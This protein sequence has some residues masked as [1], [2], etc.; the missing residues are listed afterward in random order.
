MELLLEGLRGAAEPTRLRLLAVLAQSELTVSELTQISGLSQPRISRH[1]KLMC[2]AGLIDRFK[3]GAWVFYRLADQGEGGKLAQTLVSLLDAHDPELARDFV[4][5][6]DIRAAR[7]QEAEEYFRRNATQWDEIRS[8]YV[9][10]S[11]VERALRD[12]VNVG[13][14]KSNKHI[15]TFVDFGTGTGR[16]IEILGPYADVNLGLDVNREMLAIARTNLE[17]SELT[18]WQIRQGDI[19]AVPLADESADLVTVHQVLHY[20]SE[21][22]RV[23]SEAARILKPEGRLLIVDFAPHDLE[24]LRAEHAHRRL[25]FAKDEVASW[26]RS[27]GLKLVETR[28]LPPS[29]RGSG[30]KLTVVLWLAQKQGGK[31]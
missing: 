13:D 20:L 17:R 16:I 18:N 26:C 23:I 19:L 24:F 27:A 1:L 11:D 30:E 15:G 9:S 31:Q 22:E 2:A 7:A 5:L 14:S 29:Q 28:E 10:E 21:P 12:M 4:R 8:L 25:G 3:E 6:T